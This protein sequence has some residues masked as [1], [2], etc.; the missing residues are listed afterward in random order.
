M[1]ALKHPSVN[2]KMVLPLSVS[3]LVGDRDGLEEE[4]LQSDKLITTF[5]YA[6]IKA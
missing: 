2:P 4:L 3:L 6:S 1:F 5:C